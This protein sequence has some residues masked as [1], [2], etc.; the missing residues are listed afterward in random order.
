MRSPLAIRPFQRLF[1]MLRQDRRDIVYLYLYALLRGLI[2]LSLP[3]G[4]QAI[5]NLIG[6]GQVAT[7]WGVLIGFVTL[8]ILF[9]GVLQVMELSLSEHLK[10]RIFARAALEFAYRLPRIRTSAVHGRYLPELANRFFDVLTVQK[11]LNKV[12]IDVPVSAL[13]ILFGLVLLAFYHPFFIGFGLFLM[14]LLF[15]LFRVTGQ[16]GLRTSLEESKYKYDMA[17]WLEELG[18][19]NASF[20]LA[21]RTSIAVDT[22]DG[23]AES[24]VKARRSHFRVLLGHYWGMVGFK[25]VITLSLL[26][27]GGILVFTERMNIGQ[28]VA[29]EIIIIL[30][31][32]AV[33]KV[34]LG[35][36][37]IYDVLTA[38]EK[39][40]EV[41]DLPVERQDGMPIARTMEDGGPMAVELK[42]LVFRSH[43][44]GTPIL[45]G[46]D[47]RIA[48][49]EKVCISGP[50]GSGKSTLLHLIAGMVEPDEGNVLLD[51]LGLRSLSPAEARSAMGDS[52]N[53][54]EVFSATVLDNIIM[55]RDW[56]TEQHA[57][58]AAERTGLMPLLADLPDG[59]LTRLD[60]LGSRLP[61]SLVKR[62]IVA[63]CLAGRPRLVLFEDDALPI[64][65]EEQ[66]V[67]LDL[68]TGADAPFT[69]IAVSNDP[70]FR[71]HCGRILRL[72]NGRLISDNG[73]GNDTN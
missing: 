62:I 32:N 27:L 12:L 19:S 51:G 9:A 4:I 73:N 24:Y 45:D 16:N 61:G 71:R 34:I 54:E 48:P 3:L 56:V 22:A 18:R 2:M 65:G 67:L 44:S 14:L 33:E 6:G 38:M 30:V 50:D 5:I 7:S 68:L 29:A 60:P 49:G 53:Q 21:G 72:H 69:L 46:I 35:L 70:D 57:R 13:Q 40:G 64:A 25:T 63:R 36:E 66:K 10:Q 39:L 41:A 28:F 17:Y 15:L 42:G 31:L 43:W 26:V 55:G 23:I 59:L 47:L 11:G 37:S 58:E 20:K 52:F 1:G 8:G